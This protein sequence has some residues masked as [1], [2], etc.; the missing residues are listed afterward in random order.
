MSEMEEMMLRRQVM[1][2]VGEHST[3]R[4]HERSRMPA[5]FAGLRNRVLLQN[6]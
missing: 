4:K 1:A 3:T 2:Y 5:M 6:L